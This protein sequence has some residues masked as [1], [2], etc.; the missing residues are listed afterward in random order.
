MKYNF[1]FVALIVLLNIPTV[2]AFKI[3]EGVASWYGP[4]F[5]G[6]TMANGAKYN[7]YAQT[8]AHKELPF[9]TIVLVMNTNN[10]KSTLVEITDR[11]PY[12]DGRVIDLSKSAA[13]QIGMDGITSVKLFILG[14]NNL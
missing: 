6:R 8:A 13:Q 4:G 3:E 2:Q 7:M 1:I 10:Y 12:V 5:H 9:G 14:R 11:G